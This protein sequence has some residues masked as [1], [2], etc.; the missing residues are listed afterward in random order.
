[1]LVPDLLRDVFLRA[2]PYDAYAATGTPP[3][4]DAWHAFHAR[5]RLTEPQRMVLASFRRRM[6]VLVVS[7]TWC[8][9]C[10]QQCPMLDHIARAAPPAAGLAPG[11]ARSAGGAP[12]VASSPGSASA[13]AG[14]AP[15]LV[16]VRF[17]D[18]DATPELSERVR[19]CGGLR[20]PVAIF[21]N[22][23]HEFVALAGDRTLAR[24]RALAAARLGPSCP[25]PGAPVPED[26]IAATLADWVDEF[27]RVH[28]LLR[29]SAKLRERHGD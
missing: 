29:L 1:M 27:E 23:D 19:I 20:V 21:M 5:V 26:E 18:R 14:D 10:V 24:Y 13:S 3:Q 2:L 25:L 15:F 28:L 16:D 7:G 17:V 4:R 9:D 12:G 6:P 11:L 22:E 8:G